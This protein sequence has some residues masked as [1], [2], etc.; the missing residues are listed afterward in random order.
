MKRKYKKCIKCGIYF[1]EKPW[2]KPEV[3]KD[4]CFHCSFIWEQIGK[5]LQ[6]MQNFHKLNRIVEINIENISIKKLK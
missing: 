5:F 3:R 2:E 4:L 1:R 6:Y